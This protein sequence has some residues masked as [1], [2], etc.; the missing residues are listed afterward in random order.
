VVDEEET[1]NEV[2]TRREA[3]G[4]EEAAALT[5]EARAK[6]WAAIEEAAARW[7]ARATLVL[8][9]LADQGQDGEVIRYRRAEAGRQEFIRNRAAP[10]RTRAF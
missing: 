3:A 6:T 8:A 7:R 1:M 4:A 9:A 10:R 2:L 5:P